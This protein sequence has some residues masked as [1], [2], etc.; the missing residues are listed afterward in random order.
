TDND[1][2]FVSRGKPYDWGHD[3]ANGDPEK[4][5]AYHQPIIGECRRVLKPG[6]VLAW[7]SSAKYAGKPDDGKYNG[8]NQQWAGPHTE[9]VL[10]RRCKPGCLQ[11]SHLWL[12][13]TKEQEPIT[14]PNCGVIFHDRT[15]NMPEGYEPHPC[16]KPV[17]ELL[18][19][20]E[21]LTKP[22][23]VILDCFCGLGSTLIAAERLGRL[24][25]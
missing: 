11:S 17:E 20:V 6:G 3:P 22:G 25:I 1:A 9:W 18:V 16:P 8:L 12:V 7:G 10:T 24:W 5:C 14:V 2:R 23:D 13:Q 15:P 21:A 4:H 19:V